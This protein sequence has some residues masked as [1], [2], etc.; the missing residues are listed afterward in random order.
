MLLYS[1]FKACLL[2]I[3][4]TIQSR[5]LEADSWALNASLESLVSSEKEADNPTILPPM[6]ANGTVQPSRKLH[7]SS[8]QQLCSRDITTTDSP[9]CLMMRLPW[10]QVHACRHFADILFSEYGHCGTTVAVPLSRIWERG[11]L[12]HLSITLNYVAEILAV[13]P[14]CIHSAGSCTSYIQITSTVCMESPGSQS[15]TRSRSY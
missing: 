1:E 11:S 10:P 9:W 2:L 5:Y 13:D 7:F 4:A 14:C 15:T 8:S 3:R 6:P 12:T